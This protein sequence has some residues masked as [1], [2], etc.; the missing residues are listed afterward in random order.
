MPLIVITLAAHAAVTPAGNPVAVPIPVAPVVVCVIAA[1]A[2]LMQSVGVDDAELTVL[3]GVT[4]WYFVDETVLQPPVVVKVS[5]A[6][7]ENPVGGVHVALS[8][9]VFGLNVP[10]TLLDHTPP[11]A[12]PPIEPPSGPVIPP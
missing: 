7:P 3:F 6:C 9:D 12:V 4:S 8:V 11:V 1:R 2:V 5:K 10:P